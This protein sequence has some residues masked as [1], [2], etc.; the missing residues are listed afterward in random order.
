MLSRLGLRRIADLSGQ[1]R[2]ALAR[3]FGRPLVQRLDQ[4]LG[5]EPEPVSPARPPHH[6]AIRLTFPE[7]I[8]KV[9]RHRRRA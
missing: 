9:G 1:P 4:A 8:G 3:R 5:I 6:F 7:P 2:A